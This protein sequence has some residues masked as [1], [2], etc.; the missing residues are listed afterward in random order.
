MKRKADAAQESLEAYKRQ[1][2]EENNSWG[3][4]QS[5][6]AGSLGGVDENGVNMEV[7][8]GT[9]VKYDASVELTV[10]ITP[11]DFYSSLPSRRS[12]GGC[13]AFIE[14]EYERFIDMAKFDKAVEKAKADTVSDEEMLQRYQSLIGLPRGPN[15]GK[16]PTKI[17]GGNNKNYNNSAKA[18]SKGRKSI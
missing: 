2:E 3:A 15:Q 11:T 16:M 17:S 9:I 7:D 8:D 13:N 5:G 18:K 4:A 6:A 12:F 1:K 14:K 10:T